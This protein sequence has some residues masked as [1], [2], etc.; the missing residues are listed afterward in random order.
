MNVLAKVEKKKTK[1]RKKKEQSMFHA[2]EVIR[3][4]GK[5]YSYSC[6]KMCVFHQFHV[7]VHD[8]DW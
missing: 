1:K 6:E 4:E 7:I 8:E 2:I 3:E 5:D